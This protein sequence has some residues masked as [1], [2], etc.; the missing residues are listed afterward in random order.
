MDEDEVLSVEDIQC[1]LAQ[2]SDLVPAVR[3]T[4]MTKKVTD[5][6]KSKG[7]KGV[8][9]KSTPKVKALGKPTPE[10]R[11]VHRLLVRGD[12]VVGAGRDDRVSLRDLTNVDQIF[13]ML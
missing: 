10:V 8:T 7:K 13:Q 5:N 6:G 2:A 1:R 4:T 3:F 9:V 11:E 12:S